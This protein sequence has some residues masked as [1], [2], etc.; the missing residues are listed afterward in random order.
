[1]L[2]LFSW[3]IF[4]YLCWMLAREFGIPARVGQAVC[5]VLLMLMLFKLLGVF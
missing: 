4:I 1:M 2:T 3:L 5:F